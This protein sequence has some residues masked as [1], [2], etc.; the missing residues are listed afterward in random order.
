MLTSKV[1]PA[2][3]MWRRFGFVQM[4]RKIVMD[5]YASNSINN[6]KVIMSRKWHK[7]KY[8]PL[9]RTICLMIFLIRTLDNAFN[10]ANVAPIQSDPK[11]V[12][13][14]STKQRLESITYLGSQWHARRLTVRAT[15]FAIIKKWTCIGS[16]G[17]GHFS[18]EHFVHILQSRNLSLTVD[19]VGLFLM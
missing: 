6:S 4:K 13:T 11:I 17:T 3:M 2:T 10:L 8:I 19:L 16:L 14:S 1:L 15:K 18:W 5:C 12:V 7:I 9:W